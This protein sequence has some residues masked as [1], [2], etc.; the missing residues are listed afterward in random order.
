MELSA[1][2]GGESMR[3]ILAVLAGVGCCTG[4]VLLIFGVIWFLKFVL[5][6]NPEEAYGAF[7]ILMLTIVS[8]AAGYF[9]WGRT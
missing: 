4:F 8:G 9:T 7:L 6:L 1:E 3:A 2:G 5:G